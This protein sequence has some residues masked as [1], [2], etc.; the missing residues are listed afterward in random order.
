VPARTSPTVKRRRLAA[1]L[2]RYREQARLTIDDVA[3]GLEWSTAKISRI[4]NARVTV[5]PRDTKFLMRSYGVAE[6]SETWEQLLTLSRQSRQ[7]GWW[8]TYGDAIPD[9][10]ETYVGLEASAATLR[11]YESE[12]VPGLFQ[13]EEYARAVLRA[14]MP[15]ADD[16][17]VNKEVTVRMARQELLGEPD[18]PELWV[19]VNEAAIRRVV[20]GPQAM[21]EQLSRLTEV[22]RQP[23]VT[24]QVLPFSVGAHAGMAGAFHI[25][26]F[27]DAAD[28][29]V[30]YVYYD[31]GTLYLEKQLE[32]ERYTL[33][34]DHVRAAALPV[35]ESRDLIARATSELA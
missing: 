10:F 4:E 3:G 26:G 25:L 23:N 24:L 18:A 12:V 19:V 31:T 15:A 7:K 13:T 21:R 14:T 17:V 6:D 32:I 20:G 35:G 28:R 30:V 22:A 33:L 11:I 5:L 1:E 27:P 9:W 2:R 34:F 16:E 8:H 29:D